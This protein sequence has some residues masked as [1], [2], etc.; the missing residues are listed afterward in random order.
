MFSLHH[1]TTR[2]TVSLLLE[3]NKSD[4]KI[5]LSCLAESTKNV[6]RDY[7]LWK[8]VHDIYVIK[9]ISRLTWQ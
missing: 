7:K 1:N 4:T 6:R 3:D 2:V 5:R 8:Y 9:S